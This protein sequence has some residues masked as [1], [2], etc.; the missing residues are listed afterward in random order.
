M[1]ETARKITTDE[2]PTGGVR[3]HVVQQDERGYGPFH[4]EPYHLC[5]RPFT[6]DGETFECTDD[7]GHAGPCNQ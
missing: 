3:G 5:G 7:Y 6:E 1:D 4:G 2:I